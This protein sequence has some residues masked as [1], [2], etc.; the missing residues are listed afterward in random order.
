[1]LASRLSEDPSVSVL[2]IEQGPVADTWASR[3][4]LPSANFMRED[5]LGK[6]WWS[7]PLRNAENR[8]VEIVRGEALGGT[9]RM[10]GMLYTRGKP[11]GDGS[12]TT[13]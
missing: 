3:V 11:G 6:I 7:L 1:M 4:P 13:G 2:L 8:Y 9:S 10:N 12:P 5:Y